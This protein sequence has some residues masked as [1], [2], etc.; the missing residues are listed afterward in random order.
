MLPISRRSR[1]PRPSDLTRDGADIDS[2]LKALSR[3]TG[4]EVAVVEID[5]H[6]D[7]PSGL[8]MALPDR[9]VI[10]TPLKATK[11]R[12]ETAICHEV[13]HIVLSHRGSA[14]SAA[15][16]VGGIKHLTPDA[17]EHYLARHGYD[18]PQECEAETFAT[19]LYELMIHQ[20]S[21]PDFDNDRLM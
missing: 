8:W 14:V 4:R 10:A 5:M 11:V 1:K 20:R 16:L 3:R 15:E 13:A 7:G 18:D 21:R 12:R 17:V 19:A 2:I 6:H 9:D